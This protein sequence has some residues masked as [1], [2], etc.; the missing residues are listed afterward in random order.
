MS[1][2]EKIILI[3]TAVAVLIGGYTYFFSSPS[4]VISPFTQRVS[5]DE[6]NS[7]VLETATGLMGFEL[8]KAEAHSIARAEALWA[9][10]IFLSGENL[11]EEELLGVSFIYSGYLESKGRKMAVINGLEYNEGDEIE[12][13]GYIVRSIHSNK[14]VIELK[15]KKQKTVVPLVDQ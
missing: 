1:K 13:G 2:R 8:T 7:F 12:P 15:G 10:D 4:K 9:R 11:E 6:L 5:I 3:V 14:V